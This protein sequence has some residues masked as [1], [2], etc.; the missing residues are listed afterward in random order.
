MTFF[1]IFQYQRQLKQIKFQ[2]NIMSGV[3]IKHMQQIKRKYMNTIQKRKMIITSWCWIHIYSSFT[4][5]PHLKGTIEEAGTDDLTKSCWARWRSY[6]KSWKHH[7]K[8]LKSEN[9]QGTTSKRVICSI[10][11]ES[12]F[13]LL[14][15][16]AFCLMFSN[17][18]VSQNSWFFWSPSQ[19]LPRSYMDF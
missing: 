11:I 12:D 4:H 17:A 7:Q 19:N 14:W 9:H 15:K 3:G 2:W 16:H 10:F 6:Q 8:S 18:I 13:A 5:M 1:S